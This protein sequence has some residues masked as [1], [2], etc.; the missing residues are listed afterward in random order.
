MSTQDNDYFAPTVS[1]HSLDPGGNYV[2]PASDSD[3]SGGS[4]TLTA[5]I[6]A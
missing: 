2:S 3:E 1:E 4:G 6:V 5:S